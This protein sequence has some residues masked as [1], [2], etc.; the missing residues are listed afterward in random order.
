MFVP[1]D[2]SWD[3]E[4]EGS[5]VHIQAVFCQNCFQWVGGRWLNR[6]QGPSRHQKKIVTL[7]GLPRGLVIQVLAT[8]FVQ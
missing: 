2:F 1:K 6:T 7:K 3:S 5:S 4:E 8:L